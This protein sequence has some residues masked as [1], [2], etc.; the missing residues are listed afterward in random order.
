MLFVDDT[1]TQLI[2][3]LCVGVGSM[4]AS[5]SELLCSH[6]QSTRSLQISIR[7]LWRLSAATD[8]RLMLPFVVH[9][10]IVFIMH[11]YCIYHRF[12]LHP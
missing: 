10:F 3:T 8:I 1:D 2:G 5:T 12:N 4:S 11:V 6:V 9:W 7:L